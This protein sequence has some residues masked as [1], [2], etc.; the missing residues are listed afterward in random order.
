MF[1]STYPTS[2]RIIIL[3]SLLYNTSSLYRLTVTGHNI[4][5]QVAASPT[6]FSDLISGCIMRFSYDSELKTEFGRM[7]RPTVVQEAAT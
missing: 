1:L 5:L 4:S 2:Q 7:V 6:A 3:P